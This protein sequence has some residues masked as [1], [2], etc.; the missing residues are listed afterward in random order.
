MVSS[1]CWLVASGEPGIA[2]RESRQLAPRRSRVEMYSVSREIQAA[3]GSFDYVRLAPHSAQ[4]DRHVGC[5]GVQ[6]VRRSIDF[7]WR[8]LRQ[9]APRRS[10]VE[11]Y[12][13]SREIQAAAGSF[14]YVRLAPHSGQD[15]IHVG[16]EGVQGVRRSINFRWR[17]SRQLA[18]RRSM[19]EMYSVSREIQ[20]AAGFSTT[21]GWRLTPLKMTDMWG[22]RACRVRRSIHFR[23]SNSPPKRSLDWAPVYGHLTGARDGGPCDREREHLLG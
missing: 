3:A 6:G 20:A 12:S 11:M 13:A 19:V 1:G 21:F 5:E 9:L 2:W 10:M 15:D 17:E 23:P 4:D 22:L 14:D 8:E 18:P 7:R 16:C